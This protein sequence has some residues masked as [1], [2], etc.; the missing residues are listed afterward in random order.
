MVLQSLSDA[1]SLVDDALHD[2]RQT[3]GRTQMV[4]ALGGTCI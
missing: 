4:R 1:A 2:C 3:V